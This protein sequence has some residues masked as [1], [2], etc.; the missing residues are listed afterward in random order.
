MTVCIQDPARLAYQPFVD[1]TASG[2][3]CLTAQAVLHWRARLEGDWLP[4]AMVPHRSLRIHLR[5]VGIVGRSHDTD[6]ARLVLRESGDR[7]HRARLALLLGDPDA[8]REIVGD[9]RNPPSTATLAWA[10]LAVG[11]PVDSEALARSA[12]DAVSAVARFELS[13]LAASQCWSRERERLMAAA[14]ACIVTLDDSMR[15]IAAARVH[16]HR[17][18]TAL[19]RGDAGAFANAV[20]TALGLLEPIDPDAVPSDIMSWLRREGARRIA[21]HAALGFWQLDDR[22][23]ARLQADRCVELDP[24]CGGARF[25]R[26]RMAVNVAQAAVGARESI[27]RCPVW[28]VPANVLQAIDARDLHAAIA[29]AEDASRF[30]EFPVSLSVLA[31]LEDAPLSWLEERHATCAVTDNA[32]APGAVAAHTRLSDPIDQD[33][34]AEH[35]IRAS[36]IFHRLRSYWEIAD[37]G[38]A[39]PYWLAQVPNA[40]RVVRE[41]PDP[42]FDT[43]VFQTTQTPGTRKEVV[44]AAAGPFVDRPELFGLRLSSLAKSQAGSDVLSR[45]ERI[46]TCADPVGAAYVGRLL[47]YL[48]FVDEA[49]KIAAFPPPRRVWTP[50]ESYLAQT[51]LFIRGLVP[52]PTLQEACETAYAHVGTAA[53]TL[54]S[55]FGIVLGAGV[56]AAKARDLETTIKW[57]ACLRPLL[58]RIDHCRKFGAEEVA[59]LRSRYLRF[60]AFVP[61]LRGDVPSARRLIEAAILAVEG[62]R[63]KFVQE[64]RYALNETAGRTAQALGEH[65]TAVEHFRTISIEVDPLDP[66]ARVAL[67][68]ALELAGKIELAAAAFAE[69]SRLGPPWRDVAFYREGR[70]RERMGDIDGAVECHVRSLRVNPTGITPLLRLCDLRTRGADPY[71]VSWAVEALR[72]IRRSSTLTDGIRPQIDARIESVRAS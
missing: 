23:A 28:R 43:L 65:L 46:D 71:I 24:W 63:S 15:E 10:Q 39:L 42:Y 60:A 16:R 49:L 36:E 66:K 7:P 31:D 56:Q 22:H 2:F 54:R 19:G 69:G 67:G 21:E 35:T 3:E 13:L 40:W 6:A 44:R 30:G 70:C 61:F 33:P 11:A 38:L 64:T 29:A 1:L 41:R 32:D 51:N 53:E 55:T 47:A 18:A 12:R 72:V 5:A 26:A 17:A 48:G 37:D 57:D 27:R 8:A 20:E 59:L 58:D 50:E 68:D 9:D 45:L 4:P 52:D 62:L 25:L 34:E 14:A